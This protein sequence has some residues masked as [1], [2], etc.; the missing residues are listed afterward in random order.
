M[1][2]IAGILRW[3]G[4]PPAV[5][6]LER[7]TEAQAHRGPDGRGLELRG[8]AG[9]GHRRLSI[10]DPAGGRQPLANEDR[11]VWI[12]YNGELYNFREL[13]AELESCGHLFR[14]N[15]DTETVV[16]AYEEWGEACVERFRGMFAF[17]ILDER[18]GKL[19]LARDHFGIKPLYYL[20]GEGE[21]VFASELQALRRHRGAHLSLDL[22]ALDQYLWLQYIPPPRTVFKEVRK[23]P[24]AC[25]LSVSLDG[26][27]GHPEEYWRLEYR[28]DL[29][30]GE[31]ETLEQ[32]DG[33]LRDSVRAHL[34]ADVPFGAFLSGGVDS[35]T[36]VAYMAGLLDHPVRT[37]SIGFEEEEF[38]ELRYAEQA[39]RRWG[40]EH[41]QELVK[42]D[43]LGI[44]PELARRYGEPFG[45]SSAVPT[46]YL[47]RLARRRVPMVLSGDGGDEAFAG[48]NRYE[49]WTGRIHEPA[50][51]P[52]WRRALRPLLQVL[53]P[54]RFPPLP[55]AG[56]A[57]E[58]WYAFVAL[59]QRPQRMELWRPEHRSACA[60]RQALF[61][62]AFRRAA[63]YP[64][65]V[66]AQ[67][68]DFRTYLPCD[69]LAK[70]DAAAMAHGLE[71]R[72]P[73]VDRKVVEF[74]FTIPE[75]LQMRAGQDGKW[76]GKRLL[77][78]VAERYYPREFAR[79][80]KMGFA[81]PLPRWFSPGGAFRNELESRLL[82]ADSPLREY[83][84]TE[85]IRTLLNRNSSSPLWL[86]LFLDEWLRQNRGP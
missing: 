31:A 42:P 21:F 84:Q 15:S 3:S 79:R 25:R 58:N 41:H 5:E 2:G 34:V 66:K 18:R 27:Q 67:H 52:L 64:P 45:D 12:T 1:C 40:T 33:V 29:R 75:S 44:L 19:F 60:P 54:R 82:A 81:A 69:I 51:R 85:T 20:P 63:E 53:L 49:A 77:K 36:V 74:A 7:L 78:Q 48:Y 23:L 50:R 8:R 11:S 26:K 6:E 62:E 39:A 76:E 13:R 17:G 55:S 10:I 46:Y 59:L 38:S 35:S 80:P 47:S 83:F 68:C 56:P 16:H 9:L 28:P 43:A 73:L 37:F 14:T 61:E 30:R 72:T 22:E 70:V 57:L 24:P 32:L 86:L 4:A 71:V 65:C